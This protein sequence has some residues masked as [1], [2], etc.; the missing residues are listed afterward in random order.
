[1]KKRYRKYI[2][3]F[4]LIFLTPVVLLIIFF[5]MVSKGYF[6]YMPS[7]EELENPK[8]NLASIVISSD[9]DTIGSY[10][11]ENRTI[12]EYENISPNVIDA[13]VATED[14]RFYDH[15]GID[16][17]A[18][19]RVFQGVISG[20]Q[21]G[22]GST[23]SQQLAKL[24]FPR[25]DFSSA[26]D[27][28][29]RKA[30]EWVIAVKLEKR[31]TKEEIITMYLN[32]FDFLNLAVGINSAAKVYFN[33]TPEKL[34]VNQ[35]AM[36]IGMV[37]NPSLYN[38]LKRAEETKHR[39]NVVLSQM[40][41]YGKL[42][43]KAFDTLKVQPLGL[44]YQLV[45]HKEGIAPHLREYIRRTMSAKKPVRR[46]YSNIYQY[47][48]DSLEWEE[49]SLY[50][51]CNKNRKPN[52]EP[53]DIYKDGLKIFTTI[54]SKMQR[55]AEAAVLEHMSF[56]QEKFFLD[57][58][59]NARAPFEWNKYLVSD[60][61]IE[62]IMNASMRNS[63]RYMDLKR[64]GWKKEDIVA[65]FHKPVEM[66]VFAYERKKLPS[67]GN[68]EKYDIK[69]IEIDTVMTPWDS[70][71]YYKFYLRTGFMSFEPQTGFV[72]AY[73]GG[74][75]FKHFQYDQVKQGK[76]QVGSTFKP[77]VYTL[78]MTNGYS[79]CYTVSHVPVT[80]DLP[81]GKTWS[82]RNA[83]SEKF[84]GKNVTL[85]WAL[86]M[87][88]N[89]I[90]AWIMKR[91]KSPEAV[92]KIAKDMGVTS[93]LDPVYAM[94]LGPD[95]ISVYEM[96]GAYGTF[97]NKGVFTKPIFVTRIE[98]SNGNVLGYFAPKRK[99]A[100][101]EKSAFLMLSL[102]EGVVQHGTS[103]SIRYQ[104]GLT[105]Q[106]AGKTGTT[107]YSRDGWFIGITPNLVSGC[108]VGGEDR[109]IS[110][111]NMTYGQGA[112]MALP[113]WAKY[114]NMVYADSTLTG[115][116]KKDIFEK[117]DTKLNIELDCSKYD[118]EME[119]LEGMGDEDDDEI[120]NY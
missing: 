7:F 82:P 15:S 72:R 34:T 54:N 97:A 101:D 29:T 60:E 86:A 10:F 36:L 103:T 48:E 116:S 4:W 118:R 49:N 38:P 78:A 68:E 99:M 3:A 76:R 52:G 35:A 70:M 42:D 33:T 87:S 14:V 55:Y 104:Y 100:L 53:Y 56:L 11:V 44:D 32:K 113:I 120:M 105:N 20:N 108:W 93:H 110:F 111:S 39:R 81:D 25:D 102:M 71:R 88:S 69:M 47:Y 85:K 75:N 6:G 63:G 62:G 13:L 5:S 45:D 43:Q 24:L 115:Y 84:T 50:G 37:K 117:P 65:S 1:M 96:V 64:A 67:K 27:K 89:W 22:G 114:M 46:D 95:A 90:T 94:C 74:T 16:F 41:K 2:I 23:I 106:I 109:P 9:G 30:K 19:G 77:F 83:V 92:V 91:F 107:N 40:V 58:K 12:V 21:Q 80:I 79:P 73:V 59:N 112:R 98:D 8:S 57:K 66:K 51:W 18:M 119:M 61:E 17:R 26:Y 28:A 31:Y